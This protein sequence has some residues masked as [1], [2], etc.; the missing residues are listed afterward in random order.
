MKRATI[1]TVG[2]KDFRVLLG[3]NEIGVSKTDFD[4]RFHMHAI[5]DALDVAYLEGQQYLERMVEGQRLELEIQTAVMRAKVDTW[6]AL[7]MIKE[8]TKKR[9]RGLYT[10]GGRCKGCGGSTTYTR[11]DSPSGLCFQCEHEG[12]P[13]QEGS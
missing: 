12:V 9:P 5:N 3:E 6:N 10:G 11:Q 1:K 7:D 4:A 2:E 8:E 13:T